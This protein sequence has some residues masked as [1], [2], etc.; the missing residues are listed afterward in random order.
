MDVAI[1]IRTGI[2]RDHLH[3]GLC[4]AAAWS[5]W[6]IRC[7]EMEWAETDLRPSPAC[8]RELVGRRTGMNTE[9]HRCGC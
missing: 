2:V 9:T 3:A 4:W 6:A 7:P 5:W 8:G 1:A